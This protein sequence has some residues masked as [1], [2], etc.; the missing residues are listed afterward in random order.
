MPDANQ[1]SFWESTHRPSFAR[2]PLARWALLA[3]W[4]AFACKV[5]GSPPPSDGDGRSSL[6]SEAGY[7]GEGQ[8]ASPARTPTRHPGAAGAA[9][10]EGAVVATGG[11]GFDGAGGSGPVEAGGGAGGAGGDRAEAETATSCSLDDDACSADCHGDAATCSVID[12]GYSCEFQAFAGVSAPLTCGEL[13]VVGNACCG[14]CGCVDVVVYF[15]GKRCWQ[16]LPSCA[17]SD[18]AGKL[19]SPHA[20]D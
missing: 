3:S 6:D 19:R 12:F 9:G 15:D 13:A 1:R 14:G 7:S 2:R 18:Y 8:Q 5:V 11:E 17:L 4:L 10:A 16:G 20:T